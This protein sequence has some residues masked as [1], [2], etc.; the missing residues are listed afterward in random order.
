MPGSPRDVAVVSAT[1]NPSGFPGRGGGEGCRMW[2]PLQVT[3]ALGL[4][5]NTGA[6]RLASQDWLGI[7]A[8]GFA[9]RHHQWSGALHGAA[10]TP[11]PGGGLGSVPS[12]ELLSAC[13]PGCHLA[14]GV[15]LLPL[16]ES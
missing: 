12:P 1:G 10:E 2:A 9:L 3:P 4:G 5:R 13:S 16:I 8:A 7:A 6:S 15:R 14:A 11:F